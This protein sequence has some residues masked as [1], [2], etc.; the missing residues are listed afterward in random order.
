MVQYKKD[1]DGQYSSDPKKFNLLDKFFMIAVFASII[2][3]FIS[4]FIYIWNQ[5]IPMFEIFLSCLL[6]LCISLAHIKIYLFG[7]A[8]SKGGYEWKEKYR[9]ILDPENLEDRKVVAAQQYALKNCVGN[10][11]DLRLVADAWIAG[12]EVGRSEIE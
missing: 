2:V 5:N 6:L 4:L 7:E 11:T 3:F 9:I 8:N 10:M 1:L 12:F